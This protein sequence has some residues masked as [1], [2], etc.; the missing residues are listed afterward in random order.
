MGDTKSKFTL[1]T[2]YKDFVPGQ[3]E[4]DIQTLSPYLT[5][6]RGCFIGLMITVF[7]L[8]ISLCPASTVLSNLMT[9]QRYA[10]EGQETIATIMACEFETKMSNLTYTYTVGETSYTHDEYVDHQVCDGLAAGAVVIILYLPSDPA[11]AR[12]V[13]KNNFLLNAAMVMV[14][15]CCLVIPFQG[16]GGMRR[17]L[18]GR[19]T[20]R[21]LAA[22]HHLLEGEITAINS[23][24]PYKHDAYYVRVWYQFE[25]P[26]KKIVKGFAEAHRQDLKAKDLPP[27]GTPVTVVY[28]DNGSHMM[29]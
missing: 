26:R 1:H 16:I 22:A 23:H 20:R 21:A 8:F 2:Q 7:M 3:S 5:S 13:H 4:I 27:V 29:L 6:M 15:I 10:R 14:F 24:N 25:T 17:Y 18:Y 28:A 9:D 12:F 19:Y 11:T